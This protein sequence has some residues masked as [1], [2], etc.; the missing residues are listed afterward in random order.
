MI[1]TTK[2][3]D[4]FIEKWI[5]PIF[6]G[7]ANSEHYVKIARNIADYA[8]G[9]MLPKQ[10]PLVIKPVP[11]IM[12]R[13]DEISALIAPLKHDKM[14]LLDGFMVRELRDH[15]MPDPRFART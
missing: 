15:Y 1:P 3:Q 10:D 12:A 9:L 7:T 6:N 5:A 4:Y 11:E 8:V 13:S 14:P 2:E